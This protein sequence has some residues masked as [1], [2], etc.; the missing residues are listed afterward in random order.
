MIKVS[1]TV[2]LLLTASFSCAQDVNALD[3]IM[4]AKLVK[5]GE[6]PI[7]YQCNYKSKDVVPDAKVIEEFPDGTVSFTAPH[8]VAMKRDKTTESLV[9]GGA[10]LTDDGR[11]YQRTN[12]DIKVTQF[13]KQALVETTAIR[14]A[15]VKNVTHW[16]TD[17]LGAKVLVEKFDADGIERSG[18]E[19]PTASPRPFTPRFQRVYEL[20]NPQLRP[21]VEQVDS[22]IL[23][24][25][26]DPDGTTTFTVDPSRNIITKKV[27]KDEKTMREITFS[28]FSK[29]GEFDFPGDMVQKESDKE[30]RMIRESTVSNWKFKVLTP[31][32]AQV[33][34]KLEFPEGT[35][36][37]QRGLRGSASGF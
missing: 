34:L 5:I 13:R 20:S 7:Q 14:K 33:I 10:Y 3:Q 21:S 31:D 32:E 37:G 1:F 36:I 28:N 17:G 24:T 35:T 30:G 18:N 2:I 4:E 27:D 19:R 11:V 16:L 29:V 23:I 8:I 6:T 9:T 26:S 22:S 12:I 25:Y 15:D